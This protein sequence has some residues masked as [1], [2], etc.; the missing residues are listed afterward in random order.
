MHDADDDLL[1]DVAPLRE[2]DRAILDSSFERNRVFV[3]VD[4]EGR[5][6]GFDP[7]DV[8]CF[9]RGAI[10][11]HARPVV[12]ANISASDFDDEQAVAGQAEYVVS[13]DRAV[14]G[15]S[16]LFEVPDDM[17][18]DRTM[19]VHNRRLLR[20]IR[21]SARPRKTAD[22][23]TVPGDFRRGSQARREASIRKVDHPEI[24]DHAS[25]RREVGG[26][27]DSANRQGQNVIGKQALQP[28]HPVSPDDRQNA[29]V[30]PKNDARAVPQCLV[31]LCGKH[32]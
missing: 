4:Q 9:K 10:V 28:R 20:H 1:T 17:R 24:R 27:Q 22:H 13:D 18:R 25:L 30:A 15:S 7:Y 6:P 3:H 21:R 2:R 26:I 14:P 32:G 5:T 23:P 8:E 29:A 16:W 31:A 12:A 11:R 19:N